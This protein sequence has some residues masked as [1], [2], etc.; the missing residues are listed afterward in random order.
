MYLFEKAVDLTNELENG[1]PTYPGDPAPSFESAA[2]LEKNGVNLTRLTLGSHTG[3]HVDAPRHFIEGGIGID[4]IQPS[5]LIAEATVVDLSGKPMGTGITSADLR[6]GLV[7][8]V[9]RGDVVVCYTGCSKHWGDPS[10]NSRYTFLTPDAADYL[11]SCG[12]KGVGIDFL[13]VEEYGARAAL[14]HKKLLG[15]GVYIIESLSSAIS[16]FIGERFLLIALPVKLKGGDGSPCRAVGVPI[17][18]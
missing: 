17:S 16:R 12:V 5:R 18:Q 10:V 9:R 4:E 11:L 13:S 2:T 15:A 14:V 7:G 8:E 6:A 3:T 1:M